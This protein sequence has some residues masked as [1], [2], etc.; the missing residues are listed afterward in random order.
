MIQ[1]SRVHGHNAA[2]LS[3]QHRLSNLHISKILQA[4]WPTSSSS[5]PGPFRD[6][7]SGHFEEPQRACFPRRAHLLDREEMEND[8]YSYRQLST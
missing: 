8:G 4:S 3:L 7:V 6:S 1:Y 5:Q 2:P